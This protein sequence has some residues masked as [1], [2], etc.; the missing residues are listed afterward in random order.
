M[1]AGLASAFFFM[2]ALNAAELSTALPPPAAPHERVPPS[3]TAATT[4]AAA[5]ATAPP[6]LQVADVHMVAL[7]VVFLREML[8]ME[9][10]SPR[11][12]KKNSSAAGPGQLRLPAQARHRPMICT[13][14]AC[15][16]KPSDWCRG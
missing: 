8:S 3:A 9:K 12:A 16:T 11:Q 4:S 1:T 7:L 13:F 15:V 10:Y 2:V 14:T 5:I 6:L